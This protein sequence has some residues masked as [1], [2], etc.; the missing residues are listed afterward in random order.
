MLESNIQDIFGG[1]FDGF[2]P[3]EQL[4]PKGVYNRNFDA[5]WCCD[6]RA[7]LGDPTLFLYFTKGSVEQNEVWKKHA[8]MLYLNR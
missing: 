1:N 2:I 8:K 6:W 3:N 4:H 5:E 7:L